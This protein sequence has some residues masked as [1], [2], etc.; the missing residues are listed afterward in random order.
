[1][2]DQKQ[3]IKTIFSGNLRV[4]MQEKGISRKKACSDL[5]V[6]YTTF[7]DWIN[8]KSLP[9]EDQLAKLGEYFGLDAGNLF[10]E[11]GTDDEPAR[12]ERLKGYLQASRR[13]PMNVLD[14]L[15][16]EQI[17]ELI[18]SGFTFEHRSLEEIV[19]EGGGKV[20]ASD[21]STWD[22]YENEVW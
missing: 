15:S 19:K 21:D 11:F 22:G 17:R 13:L 3:N 7:C 20:V 8:G 16:D 4:L 14:N 2:L 18:R 12:Q 5:D 6:K 9:R 10:L 1:M